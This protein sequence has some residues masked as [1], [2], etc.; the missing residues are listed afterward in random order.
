MHVQDVVQAVDCRDFHDPER[1]RERRSETWTKANNH[2]GLHHTV[3]AGMGKF[4]AEVY[5]Q[6]TRRKEH[7]LLTDW[8]QEFVLEPFWDKLAEYRAKLRA[9]Q[10]AGP[11]TTGDRP[12]LIVVFFCKWGRHRSVAM[13]SI[14]IFVCQHLKWVRLVSASHLSEHTWRWKTC[15]NCEAIIQFH[16]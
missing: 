4:G 13:Q 5:N 10:G 11:V 16:P 6:G 15:G 2:V 1:D 9:W 8:W 3:V 12:R 14:F 7:W